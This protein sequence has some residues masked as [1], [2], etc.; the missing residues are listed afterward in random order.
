MSKIWI[1]VFTAV[2]SWTPGVLAQNKVP[3]SSMTDRIF[4]AVDPG[5]G[6]IYADGVRVAV[7]GKLAQT[8]SDMFVTSFKLA[9]VQHESRH[10]QVLIAVA[11]RWHANGIQNPVGMKYQSEFA[12]KPVSD[13]DLILLY[14]Q[15][16]M[17]QGLVESDSSEV[18][19]GS[20]SAI[21]EKLL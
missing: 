8:E 16:L 3:T 18:A 11:I 5:R 17:E 20:P 9:A 1:L 14:R 13:D 7:Q 4:H 2:I 6:I 10:R 21:W 12:N 15:V 19:G